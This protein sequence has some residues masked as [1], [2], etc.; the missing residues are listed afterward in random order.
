MTQVDATPEH[1]SD[2][3]NYPYDGKSRPSRYVELVSYLPNV[4]PWGDF[5]PELGSGL[6]GWLTNSAPAPLRWIF[7]RRE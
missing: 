2:R 3:N 4:V 5:V 7:G 6:D 1:Q